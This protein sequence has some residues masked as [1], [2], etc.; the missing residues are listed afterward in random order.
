MADTQ[1]DLF[2]DLK[3]AAIKT[4]ITA[5]IA[6]GRTYSTL[7]TSPT[8]PL[9]LVK[10]IGGIPAHQRVLDT[11]SLQIEAWGDSQKAT[12]DVAN[13]ARTALLSMTSSTVT[14]TGGA[15]WITEVRQN[16]GYQDL[17][18]PVTGKD[19]TVFGMSVTGRSA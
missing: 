12:F 19:R 14:W 15:A 4:L 9:I 5:G 11:A 3:A 18:D 6:G 2:P 16:L 13:A 17:S 7:P 1:W 10:R 8:Y